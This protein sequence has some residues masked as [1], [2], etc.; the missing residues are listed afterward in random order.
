MNTT[1]TSVMTTKLS[2]VVTYYERL[3]LINSHDFLI[4]LSCVITWQTKAIV[5][6]VKQWLRPPRLVGWWLTWRVSTC[7]AAWP[8][9]HLVL[10]YISVTTMPI[11]TRLGISV[12]HNEPQLINTAKKVFVFGVILVRIFPHSD[13]V[14]L[15]IQS[16]CTK[17]RTRI[18][19]T[20][21]T[22]CVVKV[23]WSNQRGKINT[24]YLHLQK[25]YGHQTRQ[26][27]NLPWQALLKFQFQR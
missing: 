10:Q 11:V 7:K 14:S 18:T 22:F 16:K 3:P 2:R 6:P 12:Q 21:D 4:T 8:F 25:T 24:L 13:S 9:I 1:T 19:P 23:I 26:G 20:A 5:S 15:L 27:G 17:I